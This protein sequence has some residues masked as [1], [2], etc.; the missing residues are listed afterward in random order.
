L[1]NHFSTPKQTISF[2]EA[3]LSAASCFVIAYTT[4][5]ATGFTAVWAYAL[6]IV[7]KVSAFLATGTI[8]LRHPL[9][10]S[11]RSF[12]VIKNN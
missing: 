7:D 1:S 9:A 8:F 4:G 10:P 12:L 3:V 5:A 11:A 6:T 2:F